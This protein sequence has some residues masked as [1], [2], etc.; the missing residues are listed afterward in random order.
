MD[1]FSLSQVEV[2]AIILS[3]KV[4]LWSIII[5]LPFG[6]FFGYIL[7][8][9]NFYGKSV[10]DGIL[11]LPLVIPPVVTG[12]VLLILFGNNGVIGKWL[13]ETF[14]FTFAFNWKGAALASAVM[15]FPLMV[16]A[17]RLSIE[18]IDNGLEDAAKTLGRTKINI[19]FTITMPLSITGIIAGIVL[20]FARS[21]GEFGATITF[22]ANIPGETQTLPIALYSV[23]QIPDG[24]IVAA[25]LCIISILIAFVALILSEFFS[26]KSINKRQS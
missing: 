20:A 17:I 5:C 19:F 3:L 4:G 7:A 10:V 26:R 23:L 16:R 12:Y 2:E 6:I 18:S 13:K 25:K 11:H 22:V 24:E 21:L 8:K 14:N 9:K 1:F 15:S